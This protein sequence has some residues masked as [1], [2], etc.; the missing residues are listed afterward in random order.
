MSPVDSSGD[1]APSVDVAVVGG[2]IVGLACAEEFASR[3]LSVCVVDGG[4]FGGGA[5]RGNTGWIVPSLSR[6][7]AA[8]GVLR[9]AAGWMI[10]GGGPLSIRPTLDP[11]YLGWLWRFARSSSAGQFS[12]GVDAILALNRQTMELFDEYRDRGIEFEMHDS[13]LV[14]AALTEEGLLPFI[15]L[16]E[17]LREHGYDGKEEQLSP[18][19]LGELEPTISETNV[20]GGLHARVD[21]YVRPESLASGLAAHLALR[22]VPM[23]ER[24]EVSSVSKSGDRLELRT[25]S[26][27]IRAKQ[28]VIAA[29]AAS[30]RLLA[31][32]RVRLPVLGAKGYSVMLESSQASP[33]HALYLSEAKLGISSYDAGVRIA[34][35]FELGAKDANVDRRRV[36]E[37]LVNADAYFDGWPFIGGVDG[38]DGLFVATGHGMIGVT[39]APA[40]ARMLGRLMIDREMPSELLPLT[41]GRR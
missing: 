21:R 10:K 9:Q 22:N 41:V 12:R 18:S 26:R 14:V 7:M 32:H 33:R 16:F 30:R 37:L 4:D 23:F 35:R 34:G 20:V 29:G 8:P 39:L 6:P 5:T 27:R 40:T 24:E 36:D 17:G 11:T 3:E 13:G 1:S 15:N 38:I 19:E 31:P 2:G 25:S 28:V